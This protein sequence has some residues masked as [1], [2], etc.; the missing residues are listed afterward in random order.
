MT[1]IASG[2]SDD[3]EGATPS[4]DPAGST[5]EV[6]LWCPRCGYDLR[7]GESSSC[8]E[9]GLP[10]D[11]EAMRRSTIPWVLVRRWWSW[12][13]AYARTVWRIS[14]KPN[15]FAEEVT[16]P[17][18]PAAARQ[19]RLVS[20]AIGWGCL[21]APGW[22][23]VE[24]ARAATH[25]NGLPAMGVPVAVVAVP[26][27]LGLGVALW[28]ATALPGL[29]MR[30]GDQ[31]R[32]R[33]NRAVAMADYLAGV[34]GWWPVVLLTGGLAWVAHSSSQTL[35]DSG[36]FGRNDPFVVALRAA[37]A[38]S[39]LLA[40][41]VLLTSAFAWLFTTARFVR[42][43]AGRGGVAAI[44]ACISLPVGLLVG[45]LLTVGLWPLIALMVWLAFIDAGPPGLS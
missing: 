45:L 10:I 22:V 9:C 26:A 38:I 8:P 13:I 24:L 12:P 42:R 34:M 5:H 43:V 29:W 32:V 23:G 40:S 18:D 1:R 7:A 44:L 3:L 25:G 41:A 37:A 28:W 30:G 19:F 31:P 17:V 4:E 2:P 39:A 6:A 36:V 11:R 14:N 33:A 15:R 16:R 20:V 21:A 35:A 27:L